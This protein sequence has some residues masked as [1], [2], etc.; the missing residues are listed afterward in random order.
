[1]EQKPRALHM[2]QEVVPQAHALAGA[3]D[4]AGNIGQDEFG[5]VAP[6][7]AQVGREGGEVIVGDLG[8]GGGEHGE[9][10]ALA[11]VGEAHQPHV[12]DGF[13]LQAE[14]VHFGAD[15][16][17]GEVGGL[18]GRRCEVLVAKAA[19]PAAQEH[20]ALARPAHVGHHGPVLLAQE[21]RAHRHL[22]DQVLPA[23]AMAAPGR[24]VRAFFG[25]ILAVEA[26]I[27]QR[28]HVGVGVEDDVAAVAAVAAVRAAV[29]HEF[30]PVE[31]H[32]AVAPVA[33]LGGDF[34]PVHKRSHLLYSFFLQCSRVS[35][36][37][38]ASSLCARRAGAGVVTAPP[39]AFAALHSGR[40]AQ[41]A[42]WGPRAWHTRR[43]WKI[44]Q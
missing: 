3:L 43:P 30:F 4:E 38:A 2:A 29:L 33:R 18:T 24:A 19:L 14:H 12:R 20:L 7:D 22:D 17:L 36:A 28:V 40:S 15:A 41:V 32:A 39:A 21:H 6:G 25:Q 44:S 35:Y 27:Q 37:C 11:H 42:H 8:P 31:R 34:D 23:L 13:Q 5:F 9:D 1:M 10:G 26:K 16:G